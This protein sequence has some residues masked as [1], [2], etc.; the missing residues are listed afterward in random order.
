M[1]VKWKVD[2]NGL[3][4]SPVIGPDNNIYVVSKDKP[5]SDDRKGTLTAYRE[6]GMLKWTYPLDQATSIPLVVGETVYIVDGGLIALRSDDGTV[7]WKASVLSNGLYGTPT[8]RDE[9]LYVTDRN[10]GEIHAIDV[11]GNHLWE[12]KLNAANGWISPPAVSKNGWVYVIYTKLIKGAEPSDPYVYEV[13]NEF[14]TK[15]YEKYHSTVYAFDEERA[16]Q[17]QTE[18]DGVLET[19]QAPILTDNGQI[20]LG[21]NRLFSIDSSGKISWST[22]YFGNDNVGETAIWKSRIYYPNGNSIYIY[23]LNGTLEQTIHVGSPFGKPFLSKEGVLYVSGEFG[24]LDAYNPDFSRKWRYDIMPPSLW[25]VTSGSVV[26]GSD[27]TLYAVGIRNRNNNPNAYL[28][29]FT[30]Q[31]TMKAGGAPLTTVQGSGVGSNSITV[32]LNGESMALSSPPMLFRGRVYVPMRELF[33]KLGANVEFQKGTIRATKDSITLVYKIGAAEALVNGWVTQ[34][35][36]PGKVL[37]NQTFVPLR[38]IS[39]VFGYKVEWNSTN[40]FVLITSDHY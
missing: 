37:Q 7:L 39:E 3:P 16:L 4:S 25:N 20:V 14:G 10:Q 31:P 23:G 22:A 30:D 12:L 17:W 2:V 15:S 27:G 11:Q 18:L 5:I 8:Y 36:A 19:K 26:S 6:D 33:T 29:A 34:L 21:S 13:T 24:Y 40:Q 28:I 1:K 38:F 35:D 9:V 32:L